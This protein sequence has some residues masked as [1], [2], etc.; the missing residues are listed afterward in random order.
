MFR[1]YNHNPE[2]IL[3]GDSVIRALSVALNQT[4]DDSART[5]DWR[6][7]LQS[8]GWTREGVTNGHYSVDG[9]CRDHPDGRYVVATG[10]HAIAVVDGDYLD[11]WDS[12]DEV[13]THYWR[14]NG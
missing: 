7:Y 2:G 10:T 1:K 3:V 11:T 5:S 8:H 12:G 13:L 9:F 4:L 6:K 14:K